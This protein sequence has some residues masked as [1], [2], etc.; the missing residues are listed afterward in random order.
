MSAKETKKLKPAQLAKTCSPA[1]FKESGKH[2]ISKQTRFIGQDRAIDAI[3]FGLKMKSHGYNIYVAGLPGLG[4]GTIVSAYLDR[5]AGQRPDP[6]DWC[7]VYNFEQPDSP[8]AIKLPTGKG[9]KFA[10]D[11]DEFISNIRSSVK[12]TFNSTEFKEQRGNLIEKMEKDRKKILEKI[13]RKI[14]KHGLVLKITE[15]GIVPLPAIDGEPI[16]FER[17]RELSPEQRNKMVE[18]NKLAKPELEKVYIELQ[19]LER[20]SNVKIAKL[21]L[22]TAENILTP[23]INELLKKYSATPDVVEYL[24]NVREDIYQNTGYLFPEANPRPQTE[25]AEAV[26]ALEEEFRRY[27]VNVF[28]DNSNAKGAPVIRESNLSYYNLFGRV[29][30]KAIMGT[31]ITDFTMIKPGALHRANGGYL[32]IHANDLLRRSFVYD[33]LKRAL[34]NKEIQ[35]EDPR[36]TLDLT[37]TAHLRL[38]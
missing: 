16:P 9:V 32:V 30:H 31:L 5:V 13:N 19:Q 10:D 27:S 6:D 38:D 23:F 2:K 25:E 34:R 21:L 8:K 3:E 7:Y 22:N 12:K 36:Q 33:S 17:L 15:Q 14:R 26:E 18:T 24:K 29:E 4:K 35:I 28:I 37:S 11:M 20:K 1:I